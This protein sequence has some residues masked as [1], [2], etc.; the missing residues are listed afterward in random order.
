GFLK[1]LSNF[2][3]LDPAKAFKG[4]LSRLVGKV[5]GGGVF[6]DAVAGVPG[7]LIGYLLDW[8]KSKVGFGGGGAGVGKA[9]SFAKAQDGKPYGWGAV[10]P[11]AY[12]CSG[13]WSAIVNV[14]KGRNP[15]SRLFSTFGFTGASAGPEGFR[16]N[17]NAPVRV[18]V[19]N[20]G[21]GH[22]AGTIRRTNIES[23]GSAGVR[24]GGGA[25]GADDPLFSMRYGL[26]ADTG[27]LSLAPG[28]NPP[29]FNGT[30]R[31]EYLETPRS[32]GETHVHFHNH[33]VIGSRT[34]LDDWM[35]KSIDSLRRK[36]RV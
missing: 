32:G 36:G 18:G 35:T 26:K 2:N 16:R 22:M 1:G 3:F 15:Y 21:V 28:W 13:L 4:A 8:F 5:P 17:L 9:L 25:R 24:F 27:A 14:I 31:P 12:D 23:S 11:G 33:G 30:G 19:T 10:G 34:E 6:R 20:A 7:K 29:V